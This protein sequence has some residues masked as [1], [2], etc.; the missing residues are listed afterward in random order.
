M[1]FDGL[2]ERRGVVH[3]RAGEEIILPLLHV[4]VGSAGARRRR[5]ESATRI[6]GRTG[7]LRRVAAPHGGQWRGRLMLRRIGI[8]DG[9]KQRSAPGLLELGEVGLAPSVA[10]TGWTGRIGVGS[11]RTRG[12]PASASAR[13]GISTV[14]RWT[15]LRSW[16]PKRC[17]VSRSGPNTLVHRDG[18]RGCWLRFAFHL[19]IR[20]RRTRGNRDSEASRKG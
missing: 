2:L 12:L 5:A 16:R 6:P 1:L 15:E 14:E 9:G 19:L 10:L 3:A 20:L 11:D 7:A 8:I 17:F 4:L 18:V 13:H